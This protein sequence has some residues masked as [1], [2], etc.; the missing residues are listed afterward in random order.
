MY[1]F[2]NIY[3]LFVYTFKLEKLAVE[4]MFFCDTVD[5]TVYNYFLSYFDV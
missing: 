3:C 5:Y 4:H 1:I 2:K